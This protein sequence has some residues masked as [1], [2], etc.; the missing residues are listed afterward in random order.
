MYVAYM[1]T[2]DAIPGK[3][4]PEDDKLSVY[5]AVNLPPHK[6][7]LAEYGIHVTISS[8]CG[9][10]RCRVTSPYLSLRS[11]AADRW[12]HLPWQISE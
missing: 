7:A 8:A 3:R 9:F 5:K 2:G 4:L 1:I 6:P 10:L 11:R 12:M